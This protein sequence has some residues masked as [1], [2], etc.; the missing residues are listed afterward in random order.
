MPT[1]APPSSDDPAVQGADYYAANGR[2][3]NASGHHAPSRPSS[4]SH[5]V[6]TQRR[7]WVESERLTGVTYSFHSRSDADAAL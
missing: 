3:L 2:L 5:D 4:A 7:L 6:Y 1:Q